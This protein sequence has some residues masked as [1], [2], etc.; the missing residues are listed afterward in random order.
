MGARDAPAWSRTATARAVIGER[1][2]YAVVGDTLA[3]ATELATPDS[4]GFA[5]HLTA[6]STASTRVDLQVESHRRD[7][8][9]MERPS[10]LSARDARA[11][12]TGRR[13]EGR[14]AAWN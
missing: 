13:L 11:G 7:R 5:P 14:V 12:W 4:D 3:Y 2:L 9:D 6:S 8:M 1:R 10:S